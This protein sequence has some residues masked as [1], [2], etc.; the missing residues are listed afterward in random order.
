MEKIL[1][2]RPWRRP[3]LKFALRPEILPPVE[4]IYVSSRSEPRS[5]PRTAARDGHSHHEAV[6]QRLGIL[7]VFV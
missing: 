1:V 6:R 5:K 7:G 2:K 4:E 3:A